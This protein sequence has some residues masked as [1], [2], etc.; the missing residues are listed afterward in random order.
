MDRREFIYMSAVFGTLTAF[1]SGPA[2]AAVLKHLNNGLG[3]YNGRLR[4]AAHSLVGQMDNHSIS[5]EQF[6]DEM[7]KV[8]EE[9][10]L[11]DEFRPWIEEIADKKEGYRI[12]FNREAS[13][14]WESMDLYFVRANSSAPPHAHHD[15]ASSQY[16]LSGELVVRQYDRVRILDDEHVALKFKRERSLVPED[17]FLMTEWRDNVHW[18]ST[19][20]QP[21]LLFNC[22][23]SRLNCKRFDP[24]GNVK[25]KR[26]NIDPTGER[27]SSGLIIAKH[28]SKEEA[29]AK[30]AKVNLRNFPT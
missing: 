6:M 22:Q 10:R 8:Y 28:I 7:S 18:F 27:L 5:P 20:S 12:L 1:R 13:G 25:A 15:I 24:K 21:A 2:F 17:G 16:L 4:T 30:F 26:D 14:R 19:S 9:V 11:A 23:A 29:H 3:D